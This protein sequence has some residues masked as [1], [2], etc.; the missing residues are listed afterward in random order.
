MPLQ[1]ARQPRR[2]YRTNTLK[3]VICQV[4]HPY[5][6]QYE[7]PTYLAGFQRRL[8]DHF[9]RTGKQTQVALL[10]GPAGVMPAPPGTQFSGAQFWRFTDIS[11][12]WAVAVAPDF[13]SLEANEFQYTKF[14][15]FIALL[16]P[17]LDALHEQ[18]VG[19][20]ERLGFRF[21]NEIRHPDAQLPTDWRH[22]INEQLLGIVAGGMLGDDVIHALQ[23][24]RLRE[25]DGVIVIRHGYVGREPTNGDPYYSLDL[26]YF[27]ERA[28]GFD[29][30]D[31]RSQLSRFHDVLKDVFETSITDALRVHLHVEPEVTAS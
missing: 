7:D 29:I 5:Q 6:H 13:V 30:A 19:V 1:L 22:F 18:G 12:Q 4:R 26:D 24:I 15:D 9:P 27:D 20:R 21:V 31:T 23:E 14:E 11:G 28:A 17:V 2:L 25:P 3:Q 16:T 8:G 10:L